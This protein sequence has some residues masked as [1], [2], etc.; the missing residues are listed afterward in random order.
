[1]TESIEQLNFTVAS[2]PSAPRSIAKG[3]SL[4]DLLGPTAIHYLARNIELVFD[5]FDS[6]AFI[7]ACQA[8]PSVLALM[9]K[10][11]FLAHTLHQHLPKHYETAIAILT[12]TLIEPDHHAEEF[13]LAGFF[14]LPHSFF[15]AEFGRDAKFNSGRDP[16]DI[17]MTAQYE[18]TQRFTAEFCIRPY[19]IE[20][21]ARTLE[22]LSSWRTDPSRHVRRL[23][24]E[25]SRPKL[26]WGKRL[27]QIIKDPSPILP[28]LDYLKDDESLY[29]RRSVANSLGDIAKDHPERIFDLLDTWQSGANKDLKWLIRHAV[30]YYA[31]KKHPRALELRE[32]AR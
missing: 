12:D 7:T 30:R 27:P 16:F 13:G 4:A 24:S 32:L 6:Q 26:P 20:Q 21:Q 25:G 31:K 15:I 10:G 1:M 18:L 17:S 5:E 29:V 28:L 2:C 23:I 22:T 3:S 8:A 19:L 9:A 14:Y 11:Q